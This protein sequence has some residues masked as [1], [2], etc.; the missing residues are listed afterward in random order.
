MSQLNE[1]IYNP[2]GAASADDPIATRGY[3]GVFALALIV[4]VSFAVGFNA[5]VDPM[6]RLLI[7]DRPGLNQVK[8]ELAPN[9][10]KGKATALRQCGYDTIVLGT[11]RAETAI[12]T[13]HAAF[14]DAAVYNAALRAG[15]MFEMRRI[16]EYALTQ[17]KPKTILVSLDFESF[18]SRVMIAEDFDESPLARRT[19]LQ[20]LARYLF[21]LQTFGHSVA[22]LRANMRGNVAM[23]SDNGEHKRTYELT[24]ARKAFDFILRRYAKGHYGSYVADGQH[25][26]HLA[27]L[28]EELIAAGVKVHAFT[29]PMHA[30]HLELMA[31]IGL[32][33]EYDKWRRDLAAVFAEAN[34]G[35]PEASRAV[36][37]DFSGY[38]EITTERVPDPDTQPFMRWYEDSAHFN[39]DVGSIMLNRMFYIENGK[40]PF[41]A[42]FGVVLTPENVE[43]RI[44]ADHRGSRRY[45][46][47]NPAEIE[48][49]QRMLD[50]LA[51]ERTEPG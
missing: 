1:P 23:C 39:R 8:V 43:D 37:W 32:M 2:D 16:A 25:M 31:Q 42:E 35:A 26:Q 47:D 5:V 40:L 11:S 12:A 41:D 48:R 4:L 3:L 10:R 28:L 45:R 6:A 50:S 19:S 14:S 21:S 30:T 36:L 7:V 13:S 34:R 22:T 38:N 20:S 51:S 27:A 33:D 15:T 49:L 29:S 24:A 18:N 46:R 17:R 9:S 44:E